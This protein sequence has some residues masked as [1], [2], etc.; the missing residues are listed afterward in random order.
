MSAASVCARCRLVLHA[1]GHVR[2]WVGFDAA[3][4][5]CT[6]DAY[7]RVAIGLDYLGAPPVCAT[8]YGGGTE[9]LSVAVKV[10]QAGRRRQWQS[11]S[12]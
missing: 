6:T 4:R 2:C 8:R 12:Q 9:T 11:Q 1:S 10:E 7:V 5:I 3:N